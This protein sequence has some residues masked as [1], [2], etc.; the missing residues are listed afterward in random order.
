MF[1]L[2]VYVCYWLNKKNYEVIESSSVSGTKM[3]RLRFEY[4]GP[5]IEIKQNKAFD[6]DAYW[7]FPAVNCKTLYHFCTN[8]C[9]SEYWL[10]PKFVMSGM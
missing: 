3:K 4:N 9:F 10:S 2:G 8:G 5:Y 6:K 1:S 7:M